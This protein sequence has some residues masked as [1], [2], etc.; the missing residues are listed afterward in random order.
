ME[1]INL[2]LTQEEVT[3]VLQA[4][5]EQP[6]KSVFSLIGKIQ[7]QASYQLKKEPEI[8]TDKK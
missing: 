6:F 5:S 4:L 2:E 7:E 1:E 8:N 3:Q